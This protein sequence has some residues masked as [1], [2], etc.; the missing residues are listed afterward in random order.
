MENPQ[1]SAYPF[2]E[3]RSGKD[4]RA[5]PTSPLSRESLFGSRRGSRRKEDAHRHYFVDL[6][7]PLFVALLVFTLVLSITDAF[8]TMRLVEGHF[9]ELNPVMDFFLQMGP[10]P[11]VLAKCALTIFGLLTLLVLKNYYIWGKIK[12]AVVL[13]IFPFLYMILITYEIFMV[14]SL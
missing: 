13:V 2:K 6:Y 5:R 4:R 11:F 10:L 3:R 9:Q 1:T 12:T 8:L 7:S 14:M